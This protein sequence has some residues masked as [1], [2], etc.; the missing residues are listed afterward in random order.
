MKMDRLVDH[1]A[2]IGCRLSSERSVV[3]DS[4]RNQNE[5]QYRRQG[6]VVAAK[7][8]YFPAKLTAI[9]QHT[10]APPSLAKQRSQPD[11]A[12]LNPG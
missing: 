4:S 9:L 10:S 2:A 7:N 6:V 3:V 11:L 8:T 1:K 5:E 12:T